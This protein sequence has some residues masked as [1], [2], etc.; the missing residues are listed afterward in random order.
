MTARS[1]R[2]KRH[3]L[4]LLLGS[5]GLLTGCAQ[6]QPF[7]LIA[8]ESLCKSWQH[9]QIKKADKI[10]DETASTIEGNNKSRPAWGCE[11]GKNEAKG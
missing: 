11:Y 1:E 4:M 8:T 7:A 2:K 9:Q 6:T 5:L 3:K 10:S